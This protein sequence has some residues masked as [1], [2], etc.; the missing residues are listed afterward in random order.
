MLDEYVLSLAREYLGLCD[1]MVSHQYHSDDERRALSSQRTW[2]HNEL[3]RV[4][5]S[6]YD[7]PFDMK[8]YA[9]QLI[10]EAST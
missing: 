3:I 2:V 10:S 9:R 7:R 4:L 8:A 5:G 6:D 1:L